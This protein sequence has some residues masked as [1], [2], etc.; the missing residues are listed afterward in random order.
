VD[1]KKPW[2][3]V[4]EFKSN[5]DFGRAGVITQNASE[6][7]DSAVLFPNLALLDKLRTFFKENS[8]AEI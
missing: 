6:G 4:C 7:G 2:D 3:F 5:P 1:F 8:D